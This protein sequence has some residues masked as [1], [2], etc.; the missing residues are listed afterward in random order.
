MLAADR[1]IT[2]EEEMASEPETKELLEPL[3]AFLETFSDELAQQKFIPAFREEISQLRGAFED[4]TRSQE[5]LEQIA[6]GVDR[7]REVF[8]PAGTRLLERV[9]DLEQT[10][11]QNVEQL[12]SY[13]GEVLANLQKTH[14]ELEGSLRS[15]AG[16]VQESAEASRE[17]LTQTVADVEKRLADLRGPLASADT[18]RSP[19]EQSRD[20]NLQ[21][22]FEAMRGELEEK[23]ERVHSLLQEGLAGTRQ[24]SEEH[25]ERI[26]ETVREIA[27]GI[28]PQVR[29][30][31]D[32]ALSALQAH[33]QAVAE[34]TVDSGDSKK[35][36]GAKGRAQAPTG[37]DELRAELATGLRPLAEKITDL[38]ESYQADLAKAQQGLRPILLKL[39]QEASEREEKSEHAFASMAESLSRLEKLARETRES[40]AQSS[41]ALQSLANLVGQHKD[42][43]ERYASNQSVF[44]EKFEAQIA[45]AHDSV[46]AASDR[47]QSENAARYQRIEDGLGALPEAF[48]ASLQA[49]RS[50]VEALL[51]RFSGEWKEQWT[52]NLSDMTARLGQ[53]EESIT[54]QLADF[55]AAQ[56]SESQARQDAAQALTAD[57]GRVSEEIA[58]IRSAQEASPGILKEAINSGYVE[59]QQKLGRVID[60]GYDKFIQQVATVPQNLERY[61]NLL[62]SLHQSDELSLNSIAADCKSILK[63]AGEEFDD[64]KQSYEAVKKVFVHIERKLERQY[65]EITGVQ[66]VTDGLEKSIQTVGDN[67][68][69]AHAWVTEFLHGQ[70]AQT[71]DLAARSAKRFDEVAE[72]VQNVREDIERLRQNV[73]APLQREFTDFVTSKFEFMEK[74][75]TDYHTGLKS[76]LSARLR[77]ERHERRKSMIWLLMLVVVGIIMQLVIY[78]VT[79]K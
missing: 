70:S 78:Y 9:K 36:G 18:D 53:L 79:K 34:Q 25:L 62:E 77:Q 63:V 5:T 58:E 19:E 20:A 4:L 74:G 69:E 29:Q 1:A 52:S 46:L 67:L 47:V 65:G 2:T 51:D 73:L 7:L 35:K 72:S 50:E 41:P 38:H 3:R 71:T 54:G 24:P 61:A 49:D 32:A 64:L 76:N 45:H 55:S 68:R 57:F 33:M 26:A 14:E 10:L 60:A 21:T 12:Q 22:L 42:E 56:A 8:A 15:E 27:S 43:F 40:G 17:V 30:E 39:S 66:Q 31:I 44:W 59:T 13:A 16:R 75:L 28:G 23:W 37:R 48:R 6:H 11:A